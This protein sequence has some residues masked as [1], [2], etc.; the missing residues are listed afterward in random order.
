MGISFFIKKAESTSAPAEVWLYSVEDYLKAREKQRLLADF[1]DYTN[2]P[3]QQTTVDAKHTWLTEG[4]HAEFDT[5]IPMGTKAAKAAKGTASDVIFKTYS[6]GVVTCRDAWT[7]NFNRDVLTENISSMMENYN[8]EVARWSQRTNREAKIDDFVAYDETKISWSRDLK[9]KLKR[10]TIAE[11]TEH[12]M[13]T[14]TLPS[15][16]QIKSLL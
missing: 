5:F 14:S 16:Y 9:V 7:Y 12:K 15:I 6:R 4:L 8:A 3:M 1:R 11:Y 13:R 2:V 10:G